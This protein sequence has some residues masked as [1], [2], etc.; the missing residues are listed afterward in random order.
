MSTMIFWIFIAVLYFILAIATPIAAKDWKKE[1]KQINK[2]HRY[3]LDDNNKEK[4]KG[5]F[6][7]LDRYF[8]RSFIINICVIVVAIVIA[9]YESGIISC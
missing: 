9:I 7:S 4:D 1:V 2:I 3:W 5:L 6:E 8:R